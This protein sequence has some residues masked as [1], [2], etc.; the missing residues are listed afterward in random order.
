MTTLTL[1]RQEE[2]KSAARTPDTP[3]FRLTEVDGRWYGRGAADCKGNPVGHPGRR[4]QALLRRKLA[5][6]GDRPDGDDLGQLLACLQHPRGDAR[7]QV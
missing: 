2:F 7:A 5:R 4:L 6:V 3:P 1:P